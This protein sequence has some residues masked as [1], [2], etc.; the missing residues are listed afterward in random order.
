ME[1]A[2]GKAVFLRWLLGT[3]PYLAQHSTDSLRMQTKTIESRR[4]REHKEECTSTGMAVR[5]RRL[6]VL[7][8]PPGRFF[9]CPLQCSRREP[10][11]LSHSH[12]PR[13][14]RYGASFAHRHRAV[15]VFPHCL[16][17]CRHLSTCFVSR[18][19]MASNR[20]GCL[21]PPSANKRRWHLMMCFRRGRRE[22][23]RFFSARSTQHSYVKRKKNYTKRKRRGYRIECHEGSSSR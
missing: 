1:C 6:I 4:N 16:L 17:R 11:F 7:F 9:S 2:N 20:S 15:A 12:L 13:H 19:A 23:T 10:R 22:R 5:L 18:W 21:G 8:F 14:R 3:R